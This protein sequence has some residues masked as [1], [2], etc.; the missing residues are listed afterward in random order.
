MPPSVAKAGK[1]GGMKLSTRE[2]DGAMVVKVEEGRIDAAVAIQFKDAMREMTQPAR[3]RVVRRLPI[4]WSS[5]WTARQSLWSIHAANISI[6]RGCL[7][8]RRG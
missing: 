3:G 7:W 5:G 1:D 8:S 2:A 4:V 6:S